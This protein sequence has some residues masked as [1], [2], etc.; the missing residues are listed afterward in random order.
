MST[1]VKQ[2][3]VSHPIDSSNTSFASLVNL[4]KFLIF[5]FKYYFYFNILLVSK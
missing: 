3:P 1:R 2:L 5:I 4:G